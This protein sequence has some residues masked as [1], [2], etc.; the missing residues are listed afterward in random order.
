MT[1]WHIRMAVR[2]LR[3]GGV[4]AY[5]TEG[6]YGLGCDPMNAD[7]VYRILA[8]KQRKVDK[9]LIMVA[10]NIEQ[11]LP[12]IQPLSD[13]QLATLQQTWPGPTTWIIPARAEVPVWIRGKHSG[14]AIRV[15]SHPVIQALCTEFDG[16]IIST[17][18]NSSGRPPARSALQVRQALSILPD[19]ILSAELGGKGSATEI[20]DLSSGAIVRAG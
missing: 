4:I 6:V 15:S 9:G 12:Y 16:P 1:A 13:E 2:A 10:A 5:P 8:M 11:V 17:S 19:V 18:A 7:A 20:R 3:S 14:L